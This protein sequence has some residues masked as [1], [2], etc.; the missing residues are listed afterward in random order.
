MKDNKPKSAIVYILA[1]IIITVVFA[2]GVFIATLVFPNYTLTL[3]LLMFFL[4]AEV[5]SLCLMWGLVILMQKW[6]DK[7][8]SEET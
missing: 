7:L 3:E 2:A 1:F 8:T 5:V 6:V 4:T